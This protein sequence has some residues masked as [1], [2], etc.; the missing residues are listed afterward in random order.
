MT[1][2]A[3]MARDLDEVF[4]NTE[5]FAEPRRVGGKKITC[6]FYETEESSAVDEFGR[7]VKSYTL[8]AKTADLPQLRVGDMLNIDSRAFTITNVRRDYGMTVVELALI[9]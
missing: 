5:E 3:D 2:K 9:S 6:V 1:L 7:D 8:Q 4:L